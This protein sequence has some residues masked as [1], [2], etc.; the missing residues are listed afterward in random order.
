MGAVTVDTPRDGR[1]WADTVNDPKPWAACSIRVST[2]PVMHMRF[3]RLTP[4]QARRRAMV[5]VDGE[6]A[7]VTIYQ[8]QGAGRS[9]AAVATVNS[10]GVWRYFGAWEDERGPW[11]MESLKR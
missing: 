9:D 8:A 6:D 1:A 2:D 11:R 5:I 10:Q 7:V 3:V 4:G